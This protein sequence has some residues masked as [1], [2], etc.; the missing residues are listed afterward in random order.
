MKAN[1][2]PMLD[3]VTKEYISDLEGKGLPAQKVYDRAVELSNSTCA[4]P[5]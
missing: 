3:E 2:K 1:W 4:N 5:A